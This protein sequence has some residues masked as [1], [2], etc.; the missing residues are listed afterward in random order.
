MKAILRFAAI[1]SA[2]I[3]VSVSIWF[4][5]EL[6]GLAGHTEMTPIIWFLIY[7]PLGLIPGS[8][9]IGYLSQPFVKKK[10]KVLLLISP[11]FYGTVLWVAYTLYDYLRGGYGGA[12]FIMAFLCSTIWAG[13]SFLGTLWGFNLRAK[14]SCPDYSFD[15][16]ANTTK[17]R[18]HNS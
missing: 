11:G 8:V 12:W 14:K 4:L 9:L 3:L 16:N 13:L 1:L 10:S 15:L 2:G 17:K 6:F 18:N 5:T 7:V